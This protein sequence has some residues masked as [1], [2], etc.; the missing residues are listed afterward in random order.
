M[1]Y[2]VVL[3]DNCSQSESDLIESIQY[4]SAR[5]VTGALRGTSKSKLLDE[6]AWED[7]KTRRS[8]HKLISYF[9]ITNNCTPNYLADLLPQT[10]QQRSGISL[11]NS[12]NLTL[13]RSRTERFKKSF[14][15]SATILWNNL[16]SEMRNSSSVKVFE[17]SMRSFFDIQNY[18]ILFDYSIERYSAMIHKR[19]GS[20]EGSESYILFDKRYAG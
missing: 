6:V 9:K 3:W 17:Q 1:E 4:A 20:V 10:V 5:V 2:A 7:M 18:N 11:R 12:E 15:P 8:M 19:E 14:F 16:D 13:F